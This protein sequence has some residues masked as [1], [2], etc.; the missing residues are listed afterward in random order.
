M[1]ID[2]L[3]FSREL[4]STASSDYGQA[5]GQTGTFRGERV[6]TLDMQSTLA[7]AAEEITMAYS[8]KVEDKELAER[9]VEAEPHSPG[10]SAEEIATFLADSHAGDN[11]EQLAQFVARLLS[12][13][14]PPKN[15]AHQFSGDVT[16]QFVLL[17]HALQ[18]GRSGGADPETLEQLQDAIAD[19]AIEHGAAIQ[20][21]LNTCHAAGEFAVDRAGVERFQGAYRDIVLG[22]VS[23]ASALKT[24][25][26]RL[27]SRD[28]AAFTKGLN[29]TIRALGD[30]LSA[31]RPSADPRRLQ[32]LVSDLYH[33]EVTA[34]V[35]DHCNELC[36]TLAARHGT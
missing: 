30:D 29:A 32:A 25:L 15:V 17:Q 18:Q 8:E 24:L 21:G 16:Q 34:T 26:E 31:Q 9:K 28:G 36:A 5:A 3:N 6:R 1:G 23:L 22:E 14:E 12:G 13:Q 19:L 7:D 35:L 4:P 20:A 2:G 11:P 27:D 10:M 33:L